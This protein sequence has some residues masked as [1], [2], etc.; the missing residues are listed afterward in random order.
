MHAD[1]DLV[2]EYMKQHMGG[3]GFDVV[4]DSVGG[5]NLIHSFG[6]TKLNGAVA[7][8]VALSAV[9]LSPAHF[10]GLS[11]H[12]VFMLIPMLHGVGRAQHGDM[13]ARL[14]AA[15]DRGALRPIL[16]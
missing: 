5:P 15:A 7:T 11:L 3:E 14:A 16:D 9:D 12:V 4:F 10:K 2:E 6:A 1:A 13:L 8:T